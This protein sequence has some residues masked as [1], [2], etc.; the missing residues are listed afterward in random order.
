LTKTR[1]ELKRKWKDDRKKKKSEKRTLY[2]H[3]LQINER[4]GFGWYDIDISRDWGI[5]YRLKKEW[6]KEAPE[7]DYRIV[8][9]STTRTWQE[10]L[11]EV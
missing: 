2:F 10:V 3:A 1:V 8:S 11:S 9:R 7:F 6:L 4:D 5:L